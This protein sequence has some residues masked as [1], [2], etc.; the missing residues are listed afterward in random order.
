MSRNIY[1]AIALAVAVFAGSAFLQS[2][3]N[4]QR[5]PQDDGAGPL[6]LASY[7]ADRDGK[8][9]RAEAYA[10]ARLAKQFRRLDR[11]QDDALDTAEFARFEVPL[12][13]AE[14]A[15]NSPEDNPHRVPRPFIPPQ[16]PRD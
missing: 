15:P 2:P 13:G 5:Q 16:P 7:D 3:P 1:L 11:D 4:A 14:P 9:S 12:E 8:V 6:T 10:D